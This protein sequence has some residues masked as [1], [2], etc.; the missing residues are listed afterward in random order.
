M[1]HARTEECVFQARLQHSKRSFPLPCVM[2]S[3]LQ[4]LHDGACQW[5]ALCPLLLL[6]LDPRVL[7]RLL[8]CRTLQWVSV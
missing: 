5:F 1:L 8:S 6:A 3:H 2:A 4:P 7:Q